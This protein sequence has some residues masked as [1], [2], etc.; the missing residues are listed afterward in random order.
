MRRHRLHSTFDLWRDGATL[1]RVVGVESMIAARME[2]MLRQIGGFGVL[3]LTFARDGEIAVVPF[4]HVDGTMLADPEGPPLIWP[5]SVADALDDTVLDGIEAKIVPWLLAHFLG[6]RSIEEIV[7]TYGSEA[8][9]A[10]FAQAREYGFV[11]AAPYARAAVAAAPYF[12]AARFARDKRAIVCDAPPGANGI[13]I[14]ARSARTIV[15]DLGDERANAAARTWFGLTAFGAKRDT[16]LYDLA[17]GPANAGLPPT[18]WRIELDSDAP[19]AI[20]IAEPVP[21]DVLIS[22]DIAD[23][24]RAGGFAVRAPEV[25]LR[26]P[27]GGFAAP[28]GGSGGQILIA[29][30]DAAARSGDADADEA[31]ALAARL[32]AEGFSVD[33]RPAASARDIERYD[34]VH[35]MTLTGIGDLGATIA[36]AFAAGKPVV[37]TAHLDDIAAEGVWGAGMSTGIH[38]V[39]TDAER[40]EHLALFE[41]RNVKA[42]GLDVSRQD[43]FPGYSEAVVGALKLCGALVVSGPAEERFVRGLGFDGYVAPVGPC[44]PEAIEPEPIGHLTG[45]DDFVLVHAPIESRSNLLLLARAAM[46][47]DLPMLVL[48]AVVETEVLAMLREI[49][50]ERIAL[51]PEASPGEIEALYRRARVFAD[52][53][54]VDYGAA[55]RARSALSGAALLVANGHYV[56]ELWRPGLWTADRASG[57]AL[58]D[59]LLAAWSG[60]GSAEVRACAARVAVYCDPVATLTGVVGAYARAQTVSPGA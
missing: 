27:I 48:G 7:R 3:D 49:A 39:S 59:G 12:Y 41:R 23:S 40:D 9:M 44:L 54:W 58:R 22:F 1:R 60:F 5:A 28:T 24:E 32:R 15:A 4:V 51:I 56:A 8:D 46:D 10:I 20:A 57:S 38:R 29:I 52:V 42:P 19:Y 21:A 30:R 6:R 25:P 16:L 37:A 17:I 47:A 33:V 53:G 55:R 18:A 26:R 50:D 13:A 14:L 45:P 2:P 35:A 31:H 11:G 43:P 36:R 34:L